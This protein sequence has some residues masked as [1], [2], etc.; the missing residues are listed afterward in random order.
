MRGKIPTIKEKI[1]N[2]CDF[3]EKR[4]LQIEISVI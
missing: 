4:G 2:S 3:L 1:K